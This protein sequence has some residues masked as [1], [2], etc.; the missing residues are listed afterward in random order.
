MSEHDAGCG[1]PTRVFVFHDWDDFVFAIFSGFN[2]AGGLTA[3]RLA[4]CMG[5]GGT[6]V[7]AGLREPGTGRL[8]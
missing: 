3:S 1:R 5:L 8:D 7:Q 4:H 6:F 2:I